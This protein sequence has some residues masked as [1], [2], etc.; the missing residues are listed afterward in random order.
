M[1]TFDEYFARVTGIEVGPH[2]WQAALAAIG[3]CSDRLIPIA[4]RW[5]KMAGG[6][7]VWLRHLIKHGG[8]EWR[9]CIDLPAGLGKTL[10]VV[11][12][13]L[14]LPGVGYHSGVRRGRKRRSVQNG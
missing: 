9:D 8:D 6:I 12:A 4:A 3:E 2:P 14:W 5:G 7:A 10:A 13:W 11:A 1:E